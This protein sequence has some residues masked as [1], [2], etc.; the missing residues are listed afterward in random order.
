MMDLQ[1][2]NILI[3]ENNS[4]DMRDLTCKLK[5]SIPESHIYPSSTCDEAYLTTRLVPIHLALVNLSMTESNGMDF[6]VTLHKDASIR[7]IPVIVTAAPDLHRLVLP[8]AEG[9]THIF[10]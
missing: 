7:D 5:H 10:S 9:S 4:M 2:I 3:L 1:T 6:L 8:F